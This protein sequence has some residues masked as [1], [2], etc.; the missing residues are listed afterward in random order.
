MTFGKDDIVEKTMPETTL[1]LG[2]IGGESH[3]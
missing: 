3:V 1:L 2:K